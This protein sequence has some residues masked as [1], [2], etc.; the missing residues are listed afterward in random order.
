MSQ[1]AVEVIEVGNPGVSVIEHH[2]PDPLEGARVVSVSYEQGPPGST[3][4][5]PAGGV[6]AGRYPDPD[7]AVPMATQAHLADHVAAEAPHPAYDDRPSL[8]LRFQNGLV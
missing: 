7:F 6:L 1:P 8:V 5:G 4:T 2:T 3:P